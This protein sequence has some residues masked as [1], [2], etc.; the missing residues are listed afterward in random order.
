MSVYDAIYKI[1]DQVDDDPE[2]A[3]DKIFGGPKKSVIEVLRVGMSTIASKRR[4][5]NRRQIKRE[6]EPKYNRSTKGTEFTPTTKKKLAQLGNRLFGPA[7]WKIGRLLLV[8]FTKEQLLDE[9]ASER[10]AA[11]GHE[12]N[13]DFY[14][15]LAEPLKTGQKV[16]DVWE[17]GD[18]LAL[19]QKID[20]R[21]NESV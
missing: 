20:S 21:R 5:I 7:G 12:A 15:A 4:R 9:A 3:A 14:E 18:I 6:I 13:A 1:L 17:A 10:S 19:R 11:Q 2:L 16:S 8:N